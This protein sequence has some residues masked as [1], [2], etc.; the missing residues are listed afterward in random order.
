VRLERR[1]REKPAAER[2]NCERQTVQVQSATWPTA[3]NQ[4]RREKSAVL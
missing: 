2:S 3:K 4:C 1:F